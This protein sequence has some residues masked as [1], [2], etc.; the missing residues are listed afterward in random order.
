MNRPN[1]AAR[2]D[3]LPVSRFH[4][5]LVF[6]VGAGLFLDTFDLYLGA[7]VS[8]ELLHSGW[9]TIEQTAWFGTM[10]FLGLVVGSFSA[11]VLG[12]RFGRRFTYQLNLAV[13]GIASLAAVF[14]PSVS[15][16]I[17]LRFIMGIGMGAE[18]VVAYS[19]LSEFLPPIIRGRFLALLALF[20]NSSVFLT[21]LVGLWI[22]PT[23]GWRYMFAIVGVGAFAVWIMRKRMPE[24][25]RWLEARGKLGEADLLLAQ[26]EQQVGLA[27]SLQSM[28]PVD[29]VRDSRS[30]PTWILFSKSVLPRTLVASAITIVIGM[31]VYGFINWLPSLF[32]HSG[33]GIVQSL[34]WSTIISLGGPL[35]TLIGFLVT[36]R[37]G[38]K[39]VIIAAS[40]LAAALG[41]V[42]AAVS[43]TAVFLAAGVALVTAIYVLATVGQC[44][45]LPELF[46][47][48]YRLRG[49][50][51][52]IT[53]GRAAS[54][55]IQFLVVRLFTAGGVVAVVSLVIAAQ[56]ALALIVWRYG[57]E[58]RSRSLEQ[59]QSDIPDDDGCDSRTSQNNR[60]LE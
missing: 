54:A 38:R 59:I 26:I 22:I 42:Y 36:D 55:A 49:T 29:E 56:V 45:Y 47:T 18:I 13:F 5:W 3:R 25:P 43:G 9:A 19:T 60:V 4:Y 34:M 27:S 35:G 58:T 41:V 44:T 37:F 53:A 52:A 11:G 40:T 10:S 51:I 33:H 12:D 15:L 57:V 6:L 46:A 23:F 2:L 7:S 50:G 28:S 16:L 1:A 24:S 31:T 14:V 20:A 39:P 17:A 21:N 48:E 32:V 8:G 30:P